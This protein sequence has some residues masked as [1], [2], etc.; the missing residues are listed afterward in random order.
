LAWLAF[1]KTRRGEA[2]EGVFIVGLEAPYGQT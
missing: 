1:E 2:R